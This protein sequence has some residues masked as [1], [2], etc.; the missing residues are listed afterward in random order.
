MMR[1]RNS[2]PP[3]H[4]DTTYRLP[5]PVIAVM[6]HQPDTIFILP[7]NPAPSWTISQRI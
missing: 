7:G 4:S 3:A 1:H 6:V 2:N 5:V